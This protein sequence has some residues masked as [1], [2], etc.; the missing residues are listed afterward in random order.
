MEPE[1]RAGAP[2]NL[3]ARIA[4]HLR[5]KRF[6]RPLHVHAVA[7]ST[8]DLARDLAAAG[9]AEGTAVL[10]LE[11]SAGRGRLGRRWVS[12]PGGLYLSLVLRPS[13]PVERWPLIG[14]ACALGAAAAA[15]AHLGRDGRAPERR[16]RLKW[17]ND[18]LLDGRKVGGILTEAAG[19]AALCGIG[20]NVVP[21]TRSRPSEISSRRA[22]DSPKQDAPAPPAPTGRHPGEPGASEAAW[23]AEWDPTVSI[24]VVA[25]DLLLECERRYLTLTEDPGAVL[26][27]WRTRT[28]TLG[29]RVRVTAPNPIQ[30]VAEDIDAD[31]ALLV[32]TASGTRRVLAGDVVTYD[33]GAARGEPVGDTQKTVPH[34][35]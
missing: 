19:D 12:P 10:A 27:E 4:P 16:V 20:V 21:P 30:G 23:L 13:F 35:R 1:P 26:D 32:R 34:A 14:L 2:G 8:N 25:S 11:Q 28:V 6:G 18:L 5:T 15:D 24:A 22:V 3:A 9:A 7:T 17:P 31:G 33:P 29:Q